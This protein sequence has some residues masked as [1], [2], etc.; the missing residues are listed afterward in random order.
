MTS[1]RQRLFALLI[2]E[3]IEKRALFL[4]G[5]HCYGNTFM[6]ITPRADYVKF[7]KSQANAKPTST[8]YPYHLA[9]RQIEGR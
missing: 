9:L 1:K 8:G 5:E 2:R 4:L 6:A 3:E 7:I